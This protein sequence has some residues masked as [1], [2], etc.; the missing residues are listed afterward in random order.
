MS[1]SAITNI[2]VGGPVGPIGPVGSIGPTGSTGPTGVSGSVGNRGLYFLSA[3]A[4]GNN[5]IVELSDGT[6]YEIFGAFK[7]STYFDSDAVKGQNKSG[8]GFTLFSQ[9]VGGTYYFRGITA[10]GSIYLSYTGP[11]NEYISIDSIYHNIDVQ[12]SLDA[13]SL[14]NYGLLYLSTPTT[15][16]GVPVKIF[17][18]QGQL[19]LAGAIN[20]I[21]TTLE[22][23]SSGDYGY[24]LNTGSYTKIVGP[25]NREQS[26]IYLNLSEAGTFVVDTPIGIAGFTGLSAFSSNE[27]ISFTIV[28]ESEDVWYFPQ[29]VY[30][31][32]G[33]NYLTC[34]KNIVGFMSYDAGQTW[35]ATVSQR[36]H[37]VRNP[38][39]QCKPNYLYGS[40]CYQNP[41][42]T[43]ECSDYMTKAQ[44]D[45]YFGVFNPLKSCDETCGKGNGICCTN[46]KCIEAA[47]VAECDLFGGSFYIGITCGTYPNDPAGPNY[48]EPIQNGKLCYD[49]CLEPVVCCK[50]G[51]CLGAYSRIQCEQILGGVAIQNQ[52]CATVNCCDYTTTV[53]ACCVCNGAAQPSCFDNIT[54]EQC[55]ALSGIFMGENEK[56]DQISCNCVCNVGDAPKLYA[57]V[58]GNCVESVTGTY[59]DPNCLNQCTSTQRYSCVNGI[60]QLTQG[61]EYGEPTC[62]G[63]CQQSPPPPEGGFQCVFGS[64]V[65]TPGG[66]LPAGCNGSCLP[67]IDDPNENDGGP[68]ADPDG[69]GIGG[70]GGP[71]GPGGPGGPGGPPADPCGATV[72]DSCGCMTYY[73]CEEFRN[74]T[75]GQIQFIEH[76]VRRKICNS[77]ASIE[78]RDMCTVIGEGFDCG[79]Q[80]D[81]LVDFA[82]C[83]YKRRNGNVCGSGNANDLCNKNCDDPNINWNLCNQLT[84]DEIFNFIGIKTKLCRQF[85][86]ACTGADRIKLL[87]CC[88]NSGSGCSNISLCQFNDNCSNSFSP[89]SCSEVQR[90]DPSCS[91]LGDHPPG[92]PAPPPYTG[93]WLQYGYCD[94]EATPPRC[95]FVAAYDACSAQCV[96]IRDACRRYEC[97][98]LGLTDCP[99]IWAWDGCGCP[100]PGA[101]FGGCP[102][103][104]LNPAPPVPPS[105]LTDGSLPPET[106]SVAE[107]DISLIR[108]KDPNIKLVKIKLNNE[109]TCIPILCD[110]D[111]NG[112]TFCE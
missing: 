14:I 50:N 30:F 5:I 23:G 10:T 25:V 19:G 43:Y 109:D 100:S 87:I 29:N 104:E 112:Y 27:V 24:A 6:T 33:E 38:D 52:T 105:P 92:D 8:S 82:R 42:G 106:P 34:G 9:V 98:K 47:S 79:G 45:F 72:S 55:D 90:N 60:C 103:S 83:C 31:E 22:S 35:L 111:C 17:P 13:L 68:N 93:V 101:G 59:T 95:N 46:G 84:D 94:A 75:S 63:N 37:N 73:W 110:D 71:N 36:G 58:D 53:G 96:A 85:L 21:K 44:C 91:S 3:E 32:Q 61:G 51:K 48:G 54:K 102:G 86:T 39:T 28:F 97:T 15:A 89:V 1:S 74:S 67:D 49:P 11:K 107:Y 88:N 65:A 78:P 70:P 108:P 80:T 20:F 16:S 69:N 66:S 99:G 76:E 40:C 7:G 26:P 2:K 4:S 41:D 81:P 77:V 18:N 62:G 56:C 57:C 64:C 12:G